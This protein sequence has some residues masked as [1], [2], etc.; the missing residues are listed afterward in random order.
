MPVTPTTLISLD[1]LPTIRE[2]TRGNTVLTSSTRN[3]GILSPLAS[4]AKIAEAPES[5]AS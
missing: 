4:S 1:G 2:A 3:V 5:I